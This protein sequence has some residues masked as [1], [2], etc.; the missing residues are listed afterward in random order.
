[1]E[2]ILA[3]IWEGK[4]LA[5]KAFEALIK[6]FGKEKMETNS[7]KVLRIMEY[8]EDRLITVG[9]AEEDLRWI[10]KLNKRQGRQIA[11]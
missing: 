3:Q 2:K 1:M 6:L 7:E 10:L 8:L 9:E 5:P 4:I 11:N